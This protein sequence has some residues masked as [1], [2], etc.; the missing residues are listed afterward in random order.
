MGLMT[1]DVKDPDTKY[2]QIQDLRPP[3]D[4]PN[5][6]MILIDDAG[7]GASSLVGGPCQTSNSRSWP[8]TV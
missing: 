4:G 7:F 5:V 1:Y 8:P 3:E 6:L 2:A